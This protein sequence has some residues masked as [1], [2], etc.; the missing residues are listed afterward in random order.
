MTRKQALDAA[1]RIRQKE[2]DRVAA[3]PCPNGKQ[4]HVGHPSSTQ[5]Q[6]K[7]RR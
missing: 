5:A 1:K 6:R 3:Y 2:G 7:V 4:W